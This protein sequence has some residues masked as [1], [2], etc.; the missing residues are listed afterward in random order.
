MRMLIL[1]FVCAGAVG[2]QERGGGETSKG[3]EQPKC[4]LQKVE[5]SKGRWCETCLKLRDKEQLEEGW[6]CRE[7]KTRCKECDV[8]FKE[9]FQCPKCSQWSLKEGTC[10]GIDCKES[11]PKLEKKDSRCR[12]IYKCKGSCM[13][14]EMAP[15]KCPQKECSARGKDFERTCEMSGQPPHLKKK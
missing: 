5:K 1:A 12:V 14:V 13:L 6:V 8:C 3:V 9:G 10:A 11:K 2:A 4:D 7:C 15:K